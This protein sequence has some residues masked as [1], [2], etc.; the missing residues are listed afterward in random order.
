LILK[1]NFLENR[2]VL[3]EKPP[4]DGSE[5]KPALPD[6]RDQQ[7]GFSSAVKPPDKRRIVSPSAAVSGL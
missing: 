2:R 7:A 6:T 3:L 5:L 4:S 1:K